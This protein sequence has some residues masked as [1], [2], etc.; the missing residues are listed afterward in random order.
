MVGLQGLPPVEVLESEPL[1]GK[2]GWFYPAHRVAAMGNSH[3][4]VIEQAV[5]RQLWRLPPRDPLGRIDPLY[6][7]PV[8]GY[9]SSLSPPA[10]YISLRLH[11]K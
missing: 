1:N 4:M 2:H 9:V 8:D 3:S 6:S 10:F 5:H 11:A 7:W